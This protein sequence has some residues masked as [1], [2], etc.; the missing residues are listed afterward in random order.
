M[1]HHVE[2]PEKGDRMKHDV[3]KIYREVEDQHPKA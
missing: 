3:L 1:V 2:A